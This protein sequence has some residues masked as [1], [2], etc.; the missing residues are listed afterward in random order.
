[1][2][3]VQ[4]TWSKFKSSIDG[5]VRT[6]QDLYK[7]QPSSFKSLYGTLKDIRGEE[8][9]NETFSSGLQAKM[10]FDLN[11]YNTMWSNVWFTLDILPDDFVDKYGDVES[12]KARI[13][14]SDLVIAC[15]FVSKSSNIAAGKILID[16]D[17]DHVYDS[18]A[19]YD[20]FSLSTLMNGTGNQKSK[21]RR[22]LK[23]IGISKFK[24]A[25]E[26][27][28]GSV[29]VAATGRNFLQV[30]ESGITLNADSVNMQCLPNSVRYGGFVSPQ[31]PFL[32]LIP[33]NN[34]FPVPQYTINLPIEGI[35]SMAEMAEILA[36]IIGT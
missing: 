33:S 5:P 20:A 15:K 10:V 32:G 28:D 7:N 31:S 18:N 26:I 25:V 27:A 34:F 8:S 6:R 4:R 35:A 22:V 24:T 30:D 9:Y 17:F 19:K 16:S 3:G 1:M 11:E 29:K 12:V 36:S 14:D 23:P 21:I 2:S 13:S